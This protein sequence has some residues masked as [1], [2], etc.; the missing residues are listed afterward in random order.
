MGYGPGMAY[1][2]ALL[3]AGA[4]RARARRDRE[5][6][7]EL[8]ADA[9]AAARARRD[10]AGLA[11][12]LELGRRSSR[13]PR[14]RAGARRGGGRDLARDPRPVRRGAHR[15]RAGSHARAD[16]GLALAEAAEERLRELGARG[17][18]TAAARCWP[19]TRR[20]ASRR[21]RS[22]RSAG[23]ASSATA[24]RCR[25]AEWQSKKARD[26]LKILVAR[27]GRPDAARRPDGGALAGGA[28]RRSSRTASRSRSSTLRS[29]L[30]PEQAATSRSTSSA[31]TSTSLRLE[32]ANLE[33]D[34][35]RFLAEAAAASRSGAEARSSRARGRLAAA[36]AAYCGRL[37]RGGRLRGL[38]VAAAR[39]GAGGLRLGVARA[40]GEDAR[41]S[42]AT[43]DR[44][45]RYFLRD[46]REG[47]LR[48]G[49]ATSRSSRPA[50]VGRPARRGAARLPR[51]TSLAWRRS[52]SRPRRSPR[53]KP[54][55]SAPHG[56]PGM[57]ARGYVRRSALGCH[58]CG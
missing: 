34:V 53:L 26:L 10:R 51:R 37:P 18:A 22:R 11:E 13:G 55:L 6:A 20:R 15:A 44:A 31:P 49:D 47:S 27:R 54:T 33:V 28:T 24:F 2:G 14:A 16:E 42:V 3:A 25:S 9:A 8:A 30:D 40:L 21:S 46:A 50:R 36:E 48:R 32:P 17:P 1:V 52:A 29:V 19:N 45:A 41:R 39:G 56:L 57:L 58:G 5:R 43:H 12:A 7:A 38:G 4:R 35:E 23:S